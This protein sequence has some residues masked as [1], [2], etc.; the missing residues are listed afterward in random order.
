MVELSIRFAV[1]RRMRTLIQRYV[2][3]GKSNRSETPE[4]KEQYNEFL[5]D[6]ELLGHMIENP[7]PGDQAFYLPHHYILK[8]TGTS[9][10]LR[11]VF[12]GCLEGANTL[13]APIE[14]KNQLVGLMEKGCFSVHKF[15]S[16]CSALL[17]DVEDPSNN[18]TMRTLGVAWNPV[19]DQ[20]TI[21]ISNSTS[22]QERHPYETN[23]PE[24]N[25]RSG[26][27]LQMRWI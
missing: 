26:G 24:L 18:V 5:K 23:D 11:V 10:K 9:T 8:P 7:T 1:L 13:P 6:Y 15:A 17:A 22:Q 12:D 21:L 16:N 3:S 2:G 14:L 19:D 27:G 20:F 25:C 4:L